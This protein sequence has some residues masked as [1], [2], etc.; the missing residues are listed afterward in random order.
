M[1]W[2][3]RVY[4]PKAVQ[5]RVIEEVEIC[6]RSAW[7]NITN[8]RNVAMK[9]RDCYSLMEEPHLVTDLRDISRDRDQISPVVVQIDSALKQAKLLLL[10]TDRVAVTGAA[11]ARHRVLVTQTGKPGIPQRGRGTTFGLANIKRSDLPVP[12]NGKLN[13]GSPIDCGSTSSGCFAKTQSTM[14]IPM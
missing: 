2:L 3:E 10:G 11:R 12:D 1:R 9:P 5:A 7:K 6:M 4:L 13:S 14:S 8:A